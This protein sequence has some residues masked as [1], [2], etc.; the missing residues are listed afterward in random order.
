[1]NAFPCKSTQLLRNGSTAIAKKGK[2]ETES[3]KYLWL[4]TKANVPT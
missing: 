4:M 2:S 1:M 3:Q